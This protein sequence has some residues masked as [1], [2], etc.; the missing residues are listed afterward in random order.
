VRDF[1]IVELEE[2]LGLK[3]ADPDLTKR[4]AAFKVAL[5]KALD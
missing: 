2:V 1:L 3:P 4:A 5:D